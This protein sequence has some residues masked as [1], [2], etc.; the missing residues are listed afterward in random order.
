ME[1]VACRTHHQ[2]SSLSSSTIEFVCRRQSEECTHITMSNF[3]LNPFPTASC[4][5][6][7]LIAS[8]VE[9]WLLTVVD[10]FVL[11]LYLLSAEGSGRWFCLSVYLG[12]SLFSSLAAR[13]CR[14]VQLTGRNRK[15]HFSMGRGWMVIQK[16]ACNTGKGWNPNLFFLTHFGGCEK[17]TV[18]RYKGHLMAEEKNVGR[19]ETALS[20]L[21]EWIEM[22]HL[23]L[24]AIINIRGKM[25]TP[26]EWDL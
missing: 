19:R 2:V 21:S 10:S 4:T 15:T 25:S 24:R 5:A 12:N 1:L 13:G 11:R 16:L 6:A 14:L 8:W 23:Q 9:C 17:E 3:F 7:F 26:S 22:L 18:L 20:I